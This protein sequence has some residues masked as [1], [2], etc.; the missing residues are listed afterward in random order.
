MSEC[1]CSHNLYMLLLL[2]AHMSPSPGPRTEGQT[3]TSSSQHFCPALSDKSAHSDD[4][5]GHPVAFFTHIKHH[6]VWHFASNLEEI[7]ASECV[8][9]RCDAQMHMH[10]RARQ[11]CTH[12]HK[13]TIMWTF[14][15]LS[16]PSP[17]PP[18]LQCPLSP[19]LSRS[20]PH[21]TCMHT[22]T[23]TVYGVTAAQPDMRRAKQKGR[24]VRTEGTRAATVLERRRGGERGKE[25]ERGTEERGREG[26]R[27]RR[28]R[29]GE[30]KT[31]EDGFDVHGRRLGLRDDVSA[32]S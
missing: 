12:T 17:F 8:W 6:F 23:Q 26:G 14:C 25:T 1:H 2:P 29:G 11:T 5:K 27:E 3:R 31:T 15:L 4:H 20:L 18:F 19:S 32:C 22:H 9:P 10:T 28:R 16:A 13:Y 21:H 30:G 24:D 7:A